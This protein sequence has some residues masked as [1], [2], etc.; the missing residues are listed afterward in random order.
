MSIREKYHTDKNKTNV[1]YLRVGV[2]TWGEFLDVY[3]YIMYN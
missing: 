3:Q 2:D 1:I